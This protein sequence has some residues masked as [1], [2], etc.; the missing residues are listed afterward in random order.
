[1]GYRGSCE[2]L[3]NALCTYVAGQ[4]LVHVGWHSSFWVYAL[5]FPLA[6]LYF[7]YVPEPAPSKEA[8][9]T[10]HKESINSKVFFW[11]L[12]LIICQ[13]AY[14][15]STLRISE[16]VTSYHIGSLN[17]IAIVLSFAPA[18]GV[19]SEIF[20]GRLLHGMGTFLLPVTIF[21]ARVSV[22]C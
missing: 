7:L 20:F 19:I 21:F 3:G 11:T 5:S 1:M 10:P 13:M 14:T 16:L 18:C 6:I 8:D 15:G 22:N 17:G 9:G 12:I 2:M 4:L